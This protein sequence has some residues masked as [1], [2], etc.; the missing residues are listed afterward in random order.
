MRRYLS[1]ILQYDERVQRWRATLKQPILK[2]KF[3]LE[4]DFLA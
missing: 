2:E 1:F 3:S 4:R